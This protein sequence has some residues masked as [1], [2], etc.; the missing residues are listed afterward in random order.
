M[1]FRRP[2]APG[3]EAAAV[4]LRVAVAPGATV[5][6]GS[7]SVVPRPR[8]VAPAGAGILGSPAPAAPAEPFNPRSNPFLAPRGEGDARA[9]GEPPAR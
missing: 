8:A 4:D 9:T 1:S 6:L 2:A 3:V 5:D 7:V